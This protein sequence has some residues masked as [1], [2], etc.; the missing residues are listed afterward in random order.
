M[1]T[2]TS[3]R[4][5]SVSGE[6]PGSVRGQINLGRLKNSRLQLDRDLDSIDDLFLSKTS[7][8]N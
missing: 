2:C 7:D 1:P 3:T 5:V 6:P 4:R 8:R